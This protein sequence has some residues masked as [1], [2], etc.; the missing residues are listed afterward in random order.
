MAQE[1][2]PPLSAP[3]VVQVALREIAELTGRRPAKV[4]PPWFRRTTAGRWRWR[5]SR[6]D[7]FRRRRTCSP[8]MRSCW[9]WMENCCPTVEL[10]DTS[11]VSPTTGWK[12]DCRRRRTERGLAPSRQL[13]TID[14]PRRHSGAC[15]RQG[16][17][18]RRRHPDQPARHRAA[19]HKA[20]AGDRVA[21]DGEGGRN[22]LA[23]TR[24]V[25]ERQEQQANSNTRTGA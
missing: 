8:C 21:R 15:S 10:D 22:R 5:S 13:G 12:H 18:H 17:R 6:T 16:S 4:P 23:G 14:E 25:A 2:P 7:G 3:E 11:A 19:H 20:P 24:P 1:E 9:I